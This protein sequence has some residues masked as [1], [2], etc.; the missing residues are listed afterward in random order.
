M[1]DT[2]TKRKVTVIEPSIN[3]AFATNSLA[4]RN[5]RVAAYARVSTDE[6]EQLNSYE[7]QVDFYTRHITSNPD[8]EFA[9]I[10][11]DEGITGLNTKRRNGFNTMVEDALAGK[12]DLILAKS[13]SRFARNVVD[14]LITARRLK[15][16]G[17]EIYFEKENLYTLEG[18][19]ELLITI[20]ASVAQEESRSI[21]E[22]V[23]WGKRKSMQDGKIALA[24]KHFL[25]YEKGADGLPQIVESEAQIIRRIYRLFLEG[26]S[27]RNIT[28]LLE[29]DGI[30]TPQGKTKWPVTTVKSILSNE[31]Y[32][33]AAI[34]QKTYTADF[35]T[36]LIKKNN[37]E[38]PQYIIEKSHAAII[39]PD[40]WDLVQVE[41]KRRI[42]ARRQLKNDSPFAAKLICGCC[43]GYFGFKVWHSA[44]RYRKHIWRCN[45]K[46]DGETHCDTPH[47]HE[48]ELKQAFVRAF[49]MVLGDKSAYI[50][51]FEE[52][53]P[54]LADTSALESRL[55]EAHDALDTI[56][57]RMRRFMA[58]NTQQVQNQA[59][60][61]Q[62]WNEMNDERTKT[63]KRVE[64]IK[65]EITQSV[66]R[67]S[68]I[69][70]YLEEL[71]QVGD[72]VAGFDENLWQATVES[73]TVN[74]DKTLVFTF[75]DGTEIPIA[76]PEN[77]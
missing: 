9:G 3:L 31:K 32:K 47:M 29:A 27:I 71:R 76:P 24:Y 60:Y 33:G 61:E 53:L 19:G 50:A 64:N 49:N 11:A 4:F 36:K 15:E 6:D 2:G 43:G 40:T 28:R 37:G 7:A 65:S 69:S 74:A 66:A 56:T 10:Y 59:E 25:G 54:L 41:L 72:I 22:N 48:D 16:K 35:L 46:Y 44:S 42:S 75:R 68:K 14:T 8:W 26:K 39:D 51:Q 17:V 73:I 57:G 55:A 45:R 20:M 58:E 5:K 70:R 1:N 13:I 30:L 12:I 52:M 34:L 77:Q 18:K 21:S 62:R 23:T 67:K 38:I 63:I